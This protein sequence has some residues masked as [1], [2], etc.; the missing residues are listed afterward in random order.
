MTA[1]APTTAPGAPLCPQGVRPTRSIAPLGLPNCVRSGPLPYDCPDLMPGEGASC[2]DAAGQCSWSACLDENW[3]LL[4]DRLGGGL[5]ED[6]DEGLQF[7][8]GFGLSECC[9][10]GGVMA[11]AGAV[12]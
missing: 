4:V 7:G 3:P 5:V 11:W 1:R 6:G 9:V 2:G 8:G 10:E 12:E